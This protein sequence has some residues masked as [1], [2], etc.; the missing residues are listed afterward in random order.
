ME[1]TI[2]IYQRKR[3]I[4]QDGKTR[5]VWSARVDGRELIALTKKM[6]N[7]LVQEQLAFPVLVEGQLSLGV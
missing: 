7:T 3:M 2:V 4:T 1:E 6:L 5:L